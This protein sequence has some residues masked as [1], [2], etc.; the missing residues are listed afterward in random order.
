[1]TGTA[2]RTRQKLLG[3]YAHPDDET[4]CTGSTFARYAS[5]GCEIMVVSAT[6]GQAGQIRSGKLATRGSL[7]QVREREFRLACERLAIAHVEYWDYLDGTL[8]EV[9]SSELEE[10]IGQLIGAF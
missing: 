8:Q 5:A 1:M 3:V 4:F 7:A 10:R 9:A 6:R 2:T